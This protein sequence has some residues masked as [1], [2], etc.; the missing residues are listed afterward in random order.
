MSSVQFPSLTDLCA[1]HFAN[2]LGKMTKAQVRQLPADV[3]QRIAEFI[4]TTPLKHLEHCKAKDL[5]KLRTIRKVSID[6]MHKECIPYLKGS[7]IEKL[8]IENL[9]HIPTKELF[10]LIPTFK[11][12][13]SFSFHDSNSN[14]GP[15]LNKKFTSC[16]DGGRTIL[17]VCPQLR[18]FNLEFAKLNEGDE[19]LLTE[20]VRNSK[21]RF[22]GLRYVDDGHHYS[23][24]C[25]YRIASAALMANKISTLILKGYS[26]E[27]GLTALTEAMQKNTS[28]KAISLEE[29]KCYNIEPLLNFLEEIQKHKHVTRLNLKHIGLR[30]NEESE[31]TL[32]LTAL[33]AQIPHLQELS[34]E[35][36]RLTDENLKHFTQTIKNNHSLKTLNLQQNKL[37]VEGI[38]DFILALKGNGILK[39]LNLGWNREYEAPE[40]S[41]NPIALALAPL[42]ANNTIG[43]THLSLQSCN[44]GKEGA[45]AL[46]HAL[47]TNATLKYL[48]LSH[49]QLGEEGID[50]LIEALKVN[51]T[52]KTLMLSGNG[53]SPAQAEILYQ[54][55][56]SKGIDFGLDFDAILDPVYRQQKQAA[57]DTCVIA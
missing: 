30:D 40:G 28:L 33:L 57:M 47:N 24:S 46:A 26:A 39:K 36:T 7:Q 37:S 1:M 51:K 8:T 42:F 54:L 50:A 2:N 18:K 21:L 45:L 11:K 32:K 48:D 25:A 38:V 43:L 9:V 13:T 31:D 29:N 5:A 10:D 55:S 3:Q 6:F 35:S 52:I 16:V 19:K 22:L 4:M 27:E 12:L 20:S 14:Q 56:A 17:D 53:V 41:G 34:L 49:N 15:E 23:S 44:I